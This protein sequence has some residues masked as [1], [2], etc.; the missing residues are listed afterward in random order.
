[1]YTPPDD[2]YQCHMK[3]S[4]VL[5]PFRNREHC[6]VYALLTS[7]AYGFL[8]VADILTQMFFLMVME[9]CT[10][11]L[12]NLNRMAHPYPS[13]IGL[14][15]EVSRANV[16]NIKPAWQETYHKGLQALIDISVISI[17]AETRL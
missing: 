12:C 16:R 17:C 4:S 7:S 11:I 2:G 13:S 15:S 6:P 1:M 5:P 10:E 8:H 14:I 3:I 9:F